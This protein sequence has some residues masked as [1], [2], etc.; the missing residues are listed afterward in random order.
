[1]LELGFGLCWGE[2]QIGASVDISVEGS[3]V[4]P[5]VGPTV[6]SGVGGPG[7]GV[8]MGT[9]FWARCG[10]CS[11]TRCWISSVTRP[12]TWSWT[13]RGARCA[14]MTC[15]KEAAIIGLALCKSVIIEM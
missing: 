8:G 11:E 3:G 4:G 1:M 2:A 6:G 12:G 13:R 15:L 9:R 14:T 10:C 5:E 7:P